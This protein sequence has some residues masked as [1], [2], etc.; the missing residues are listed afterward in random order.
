MSSYVPTDWVD[1][2]TPLD[3]AHFDKIEQAIRKRQASE[4]GAL[5]AAATITVTE[6]V[7]AVN[8]GATIS[9]IN[10]GVAGQLLLLYAVSGQTFTLDSAGNIW[11]TPAG[12]ALVIASNQAVLLYFTGSQWRT[13][14]SPSAGGGG[15]GG[16]D[17][18]GAWAGAT[19]YVKGDV[20]TH[21]GV[22]YG[23]VND[24]TGQTPPAA[25]AAPG[26][27]PVI[28]LV[29]SLPASPFDGQEVILVDVVGAAT[30]AWRLR[31]VQ[32]RVTNKWIYLGGSP[33][34]AFAGAAGTDE[35]TNSFVPTDLATVGPGVTV[36][37]AG[38]YR[39]WMASRMSNSAG[40]NFTVIY[41][42]VGAAA[43]IE[44]GR[45]Q[46]GG[47]H[48]M[49]SQSFDFSALAGDLVK[50]QYA[51]AAGTG[52]YTYRQIQVEPIAVGG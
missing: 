4:G 32:A 24:S 44:M 50:L 30:Y 28:P 21:N 12:G 42:K 16:L 45:V 51:V 1:G 39:L 15:G 11:A 43:A 46:P 19:P 6:A 36:P 14:G 18:E 29:T 22:T 3:E 7:H 23:A 31:Y 35:T 17:W 48:I 26:A 37:V 2:T 5:T 20:V 41:Y 10:G 9:T 52:Y 27:L 49:F 34:R 40:G 38:L 47:A 13:V 25:Q 8:S 33:L